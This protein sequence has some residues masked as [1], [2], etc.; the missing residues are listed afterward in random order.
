MVRYIIKKIIDLGDD[1]TFK[2]MCTI[3]E[4]K[5]YEPKKLW[6]KEGE[7]YKESFYM[8]WNMKFIVINSS[9][10]RVLSYREFNDKIHEGKYLHS[11]KRYVNYKGD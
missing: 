7:K 9:G 3:L 10:V 4:M 5:G 6:E 1:G 2:Y 11:R 8:R